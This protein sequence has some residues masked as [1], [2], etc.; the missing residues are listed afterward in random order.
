MDD[1]PN[2]SVEDYIFN[3]AFFIKLTLN[4]EDYLEGMLVSYFNCYIKDFIIRFNIWMKDNES[5]FEFNAIKVNKKFQAL[6]APYNPRSQQ[7]YVDYNNCVDDILNI[8]PPYHTNAH[9]N[10]TYQSQPGSQLGLNKKKVQTIPFNASPHQ[11]DWGKANA[12]KN[13]P[14]D[15]LLSNNNKNLDVKEEAKEMNDV[16]NTHRE[17]QEKIRNSIKVDI[18]DFKHEVENKSQDIAS[19]I[20]QASVTKLYG[21]K[22]ENLNQ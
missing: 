22:E 12:F 18:S 3:T 20:F 6:N 4:D 11:I 16:P 1:N 14:E 7:E 2:Y 5:P 13:H 9:Y 10:P 15:I 17:R 21:G 8:C 19:V